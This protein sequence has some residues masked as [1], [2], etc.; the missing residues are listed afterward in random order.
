[1]N[2]LGLQWISALERLAFCCFSQFGYDCIF[3]RLWWTVIRLQ[4]EVIMKLVF[5]I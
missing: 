2:N 1:M 3:G 4:L 5:S